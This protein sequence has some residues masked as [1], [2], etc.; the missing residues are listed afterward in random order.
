[1]SNEFS[2]AAKIHVLGL[3]PLRR[4]LGDKWDRLSALVHQ[5]FE[6][7][8]GRAQGPSDHFTSLEDLPHFVTFHDFSP[9][10]ANL[11]CTAIA[12]TVCQ[13]LFGD[14]IDEVAVRSLVSEITMPK[15]STVALDGKMIEQLLEKFGT[16]VVISKS[17]HSSS[18][19]PVVLHTGNP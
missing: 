9:A 13:K 7:A 3:S 5:L 4:R 1:M 6:T 2:S 16:E 18:S 10:E 15:D 11:A 12:K 17:R 14:Q 8:L 19:E